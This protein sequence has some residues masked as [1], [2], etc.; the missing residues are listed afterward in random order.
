MDVD[1]GFVSICTMVI[2]SRWFRLLDLWGL[3]SVKSLI[4]LSSCAYRQ[5]FRFGAGDLTAKSEV[6]PGYRYDT[7]MVSNVYQTTYSYVWDL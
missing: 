3:L 2:Y 5:G 4:K 7:Q 1:G 6:M